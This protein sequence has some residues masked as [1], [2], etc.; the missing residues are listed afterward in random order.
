MSLVE[1]WKP[2]KGYEDFYEVSNTGKIRSLPH[3]TKRVGTGKVLKAH[4]SN[5]GYFIVRYR[6]PDERA[7]K[8][9]LV[10]REFAK[11]FIPN[12][13]NLSDVNHKDGNKINNSIENLEWCSHTD[14]V[15]HAFKTGLVA[16]GEDRKASRLTSK[17]VKEIR[18]KYIPRTYSQYKLAKE[19]GVS[20]STIRFALIGRTWKGVA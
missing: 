19:Y 4:L 11:A 9:F 17:A 20:Q 16:S 3:P 2:I 18:E 13:H 6:R 1:V 14:N 15:R 12:P 5:Q 7:V 8:A 10:H